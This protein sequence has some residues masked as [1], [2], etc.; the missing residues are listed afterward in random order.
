MNFDKLNNWLSLLANVG[1]V[2]GIIFLA[3]E[4]RTNTS[5]NR[6]AI[7]QNYS[8]NWMHIHAQLAE[9]KELASLVETALSGGELDSVQSRQF[10]RWALQFVTQAHD[11]L[12]HYDEGLISESELRSAFNNIRN[13]AI[14]PRFGLAL[15]EMGL[16]EDSRLGGLIL[17]ENGYE[18]WLH[19]RE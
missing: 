5:T 19:V 14:N 4:V 6:I 15:E 12:R 1:V 2:V 8:N 17:D 11:M 18:K 7:L 16:D 3:I 13:M 9:N 10:R